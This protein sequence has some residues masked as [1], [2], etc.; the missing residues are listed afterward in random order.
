[1]LFTSPPI[2]RR[3][4]KGSTSGER[5]GDLQRLG[6]GEVALDTYDGAVLV[7]QESVRGQAQ[8]LVAELAVGIEKDE[9]V[10]LA[11]DPVALV[12]TDRHL[13]HRRAV[14]EQIGR[15]TSEL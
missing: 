7:D 6:F 4:A 15:A 13:L 11:G 5:A 8:R 14:P 1:M 9:D 12:P 3:P 10:G 2:H